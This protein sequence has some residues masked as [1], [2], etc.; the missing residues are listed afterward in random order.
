MGCWN[1]TCALSNLPIF[2][3]EETYVFV[4]ERSVGYGTDGGVYTHHMFRPCL[5]PFEALYDDYGSGE[6]NKGVG[7]SWI[8]EGIR[9]ELVEV[10]QGENKY[11]DIPVKRDGF[12]VSA[13]YE[14]AREGRL[15]LKGYPV[16]GYQE[17]PRLHIVMMRKDVVDRVLSEISYERYNSDSSD[18]TYY[19]FNDILDSIDE[20]IEYS[21][22]YIEKSD[23]DPDRLSFSL[24][25]RPSVLLLPWRTTN[26]A[27]NWLRSPFESR[28]P[29]S[30]IF[31]MSEV[32]S[33]LIQKGEL[34]EAKELITE[35][36]KGVCINEFM[37][38][39]RR[40]WAP[41]SGEGSQTDALKEHKLLASITTSVADKL[42]HRWDED[43]EDGDPDWVVEQ[44]FLGFDPEPQGAQ[45]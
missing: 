34:T 15:K 6:D 7:L 24:I 4:I 13:L 3:G 27:S 41:P 28:S 9:N 22:K 35:F 43:D 16:I 37:D 44:S 11:H 31:S 39:T 29:Q 45:A 32:Y 25:C 38:S 19:T 1:K 20:M 17:N 30:Q 14:T 42:E 10:E 23:E 21:V 2:H 18:Y 36:L 5:L 40:M 26:H 8:I 33:K 12:D